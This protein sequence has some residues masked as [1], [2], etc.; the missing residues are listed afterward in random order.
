MSWLV[1]NVNTKNTDGSIPCPSSF[2]QADMP[3]VGV[4][5]HIP[6]GTN[7][8]YAEIMPETPR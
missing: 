7:L 5:F 3:I 1:Q 4:H 6:F 8:V 2:W